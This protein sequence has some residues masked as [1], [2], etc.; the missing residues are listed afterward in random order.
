[1]CVQEPQRKHHY[2]K[3]HPVID[4]ALGRQRE[5]HRIAVVR[6]PDLN[7]RREYGVGR[8]Q[9]R[10]QEK[11]NGPR[12][13]KHQ[14]CD[15]CCEHDARQHS[16]PCQPQGV[17]ARCDA[18]SGMRSFNPTA[19]SDTSTAIS[20]STSTTAPSFT[21]SMASRPTPAGPIAHP[22]AK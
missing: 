14:P 18:S 16:P 4:R 12:Q 6:R 21:G 17:R 19:N 1:M 20:A 5:A 8:R 2:G 7:V 3:R 9:H 11:R 15:E 13:I 22:T 10:P